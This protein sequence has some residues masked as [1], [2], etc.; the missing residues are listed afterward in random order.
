MIQDNLFWVIF[1]IIFILLLII[2]TDEVDLKKALVKKCEEFVAYKLHTIATVMRSNQSALE[3]ESKSSA[4]DKHETGRAMLHLEMEKTSQQ[5]SVASKMK[6]ILDR[7]DV[8]KGTEVIK[9]GSVIHTDKGS[10]F[11][12]ISA[13]VVM[14]KGMEYF[15]VSPYSPIGT[16]LLGKKKGSVI[17]VAQRQIKVLEVI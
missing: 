4:G 16:L 3:N 15:A 8:G 11:L 9:L 2:K 17:S 5:L 6:V 13:G 14:I 7:I 10:Y 1:S 12:S